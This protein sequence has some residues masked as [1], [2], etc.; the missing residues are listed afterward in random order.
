MTFQQLPTTRRGDVGEV[1]AD[2]YF[3]AQGWHSYKPPTGPPHPVDRVLMT[4]SGIFAVDVKTYARQFSRPST[5]ID[6][7][8]HKKYLTIEDGGL[9]VV[10]FFIDPFEGCIYSG[11]ISQLRHVATNV[12]EKTYYPLTAMRFTRRLTEQERKLLH[13]P[14]DPRYTF[15]QPFFA[16]NQPGY[17][18]N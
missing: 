10:L 18:A 1:I 15:T 6:T 13:A 8:D 9:P 11:R 2:R 5:G 12:N 17:H 7:A 3:D 4:K 14:A 16:I